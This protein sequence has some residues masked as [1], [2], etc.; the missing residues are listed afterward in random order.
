MEPEVPLVVPEINAADLEGH[1][2][3]IAIPNCSTT[4]MVMALY[5][6]HRVNPI[7]RVIV[8]TYQSVSGTGGAAMSELQEQMREVISGG[9][10]K[11]EQYPHQIA[12][13]VFPHIEPFLDNGYT[14]E[15]WKMLEETRKIMHAPGHPGLRHL[16]AGAGAGG[17]QRGGARRVQPAHGSP[18]GPE[19]AGRFPWRD[20]GGRSGAKQVPHANNGCGMRRG[21]RR[22]DTERCIS[23]QRLDHVG[24]VG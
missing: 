17:P 21:V 11:A 7:K 1:R 13:N 10:P 22:S 16:C 24:G 9:Q 6:L 12:Q 4:Q 19:A 15:E 18:G 2:G 5:P 8:D 20:G 3:I 23:P 14:R